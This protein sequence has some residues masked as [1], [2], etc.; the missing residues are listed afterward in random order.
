MVTY[1]TKFENGKIF[2][3]QVKT[4]KTI[5]DVVEGQIYKSMSKWSKRIDN[6]KKKAKI[7]VQALI[8]ERIKEGFELTKFEEEREN[9]FDVYDK[10]K[11]HY[12]GDFPKELDN[13]QA[14]IH[15][16]MFITWL[17]DNNLLDNDFVEECEEQ[18]EKVK[19]RK[20]TGSQFYESCMDGVFSIDEVSEL[21][22]AFALRY[23]DSKT[24]KYIDDYSEVCSDDLPTLYHLEDTWDNYGKIKK[25]IEY[26][27]KQW[28]EHNKSILKIVGKNKNELDLS[29]MSRAVISKNK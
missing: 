20:L 10:A 3:F 1:L 12:G 29:F 25:V 19:Q 28:E 24:G 11:Y 17:I 16:G 27:Y 8:D 18:I 14:H 23:L 5:L 9:T 26:R 2:H 6:D 4:S 15:T 13:F 21:G 7:E 22:N